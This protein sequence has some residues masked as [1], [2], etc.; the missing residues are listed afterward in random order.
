MDKEL[1]FQLILDN[2]TG[3]YFLHTKNNYYKIPKDSFKSIIA[4]KLPKN[5]WDDNDIIIALN[6]FNN[7]KMFSCERQKKFYDFRAKVFTKKVYEYLEV[8]AE[9]F[10]EVYEVI[11][12]STASLHDIK[13]KEATESIKEYVKK[14][15]KLFKLNLQSRR[16]EL[17]S[18]SDWTQMPDLEIDESSRQMWKKYRKYLRDLGDEVNWIIGDVFK[19]DFPISPYE[20]KEIDP[21]Q[22]EE[23]L[24]VP[25]H[26]I[27]P[28]VMMTKLKL[29]KILERI[30]NLDELASKVPGISDESTSEAH[31]YEA[32]RKGNATTKLND[33]TTTLAKVNL[34]N[35]SD[36]VNERLQKIDPNYVWDISVI[37]AS[38]CGD[39][40]S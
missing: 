32:I 36:Y 38:D 15:A 19:V 34:E 6:S 20:Y 4:D 17:L 11:T 5:W 9:E 29:L 18:S 3:D 1:D 27:N 39:C 13:L 35:L 7:G 40:K 31:I 22:K 25:L 24:S 12:N 14:Q 16:R 23:Y 26:F 2:E 21:E 10:K 37:D 8:D 33:L 28:A 30:G